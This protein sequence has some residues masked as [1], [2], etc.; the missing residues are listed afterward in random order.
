[1]GVF[2]I[3]AAELH[4]QEIEE[5]LQKLNREMQST[6]EAIKRAEAQYNQVRGRIAVL[7]EIAA[8]EREG[9]AYKTRTTEHKPRTSNPSRG[10]VADLALAMIRDAGHPLSRTELYDGLTANGLKLE[11]KDPL[12]VFS[13]ML[14]R[15]RDRV[16][17]IRGHGYWPADQPYPPARYFPEEPE[18]RLI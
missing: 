9:K 6:Q 5:R 4:R 1:M 3:A 11:G 10:Q 14:W 8:A 17:R 18:P 2:D 16:T 13:T 15:E 12:M 7:K